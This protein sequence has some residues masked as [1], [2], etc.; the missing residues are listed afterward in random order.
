M[1]LSKRGFAKLGAYWLTRS[2]SF[3]L[4]VALV[5]P[6][7]PKKP[8]HLPTSYASTEPH[9]EHHPQCKPGLLQTEDFSI[10]AMHRPSSR[11]DITSTAAFRHRDAALRRR[12][13]KQTI[14]VDHFAKATIC[15]LPTQLQSAASKN[16]TSRTERP[17]S[18]KRPPI[19][20]PAAEWVL[21]LVRMSSLGWL[22]SS[23]DQHNAHSMPCIRRRNVAWR[24]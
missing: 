2:S 5:P 17:L 15:A 7:H 3:E 16:A 13:P 23:G 1:P 11:A 18:G 20:A 10:L 21:C 12:P 19:F 6:I 4:A 14:V 8:S 22:P 9:F 24:L